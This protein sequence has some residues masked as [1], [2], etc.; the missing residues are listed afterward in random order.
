MQKDKNKKWGKLNES[1]K[2]QEK[3]KEKIG[4]IRKEK[5]NECVL[6]EKEWDS[7]R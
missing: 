3:I 1:E 7:G 5:K 2:D 6:N 4:S